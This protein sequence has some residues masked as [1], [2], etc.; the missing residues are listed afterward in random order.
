MI[1]KGRD[2]DVLIKVE[3]SNPE[4]KEYRTKLFTDFG[5]GVVDTH[6]DEFNEANNPT[7]GYIILGCLKGRL[8]LGVPTLL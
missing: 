1:Y 4:E 2:Y 8:P 3:Y 6:F 5:W 7:H